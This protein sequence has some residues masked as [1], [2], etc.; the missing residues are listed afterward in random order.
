[1]ICL[2]GSR[3]PGARVRQAIP[4]IM[5][6]G[7]WVRVCSRGSCRLAG[8]SLIEPISSL[9]PAPSFTLRVNKRILLGRSCSAS[10]GTAI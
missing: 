8:S 10:P 9:R 7:A 5:Y 1:M 2:A 3:G 4:L 6:A